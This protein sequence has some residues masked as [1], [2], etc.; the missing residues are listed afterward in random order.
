MPDPMGMPDMFW[1]KGMV[2]GL[3][4][5]LSPNKTQYALFFDYGAWQKRSYSTKGEA[6]DDFMKLCRQIYPDDGIEY[7][8]KCWTMPTDETEKQLNSLLGEGQ[9]LAVLQS[10]NAALSRSTLFRSEILAFKAALLDDMIETTNYWQ[11]QDK[12]LHELDAIIA[13]DL[14]AVLSQQDRIALKMRREQLTHP[15]Q[16]HLVFNK[17]AG[18][19]NGG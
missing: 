19:K 1:L 6:D 9:H 14:P 18:N 10:C 11:T 16:N 8:Y 3:V 5:Q 7:T 4:L 2:H 15:A 17:R 13:A 12:I